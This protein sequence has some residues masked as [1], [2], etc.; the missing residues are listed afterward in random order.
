MLSDIRC[1]P[2]CHRPPPSSA[3]SSSS[4]SSNN[5]RA[6]CPPSCP[7]LWEM[8][9]A[10]N[11]LWYTHLRHWQFPLSPT[12]FLGKQHTMEEEWRTTEHLDN[13]NKVESKYVKREQF[14]QLCVFAEVMLFIVCIC[15]V[16]VLSVVP[17][18][19]TIAIYHMMSGSKMWVEGMGNASKQVNI[20]KGMKRALKDSKTYSTKYIYIKY[21]TATAQIL[22]CHSRIYIL[23][24][25]G[26]SIHIRQ[27]FNKR[28][29]VH[30]SFILKHFR[31]KTTNKRNK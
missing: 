10:R 19:G 29:C 26:G 25:F 12:K 5:W 18:Q 30:M 7:L 6:H 13:K 22:Y 4:N 27:N 3:G 8:W 9:S 24:T 21:A 16:Y 11:W 1:V 20:Q 15:G 17:M 28:L 14:D 31:A 2:I 23:S